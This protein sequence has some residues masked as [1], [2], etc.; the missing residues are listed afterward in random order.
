MPV[1]NVTKA[2]ST[3]LPDVDNSLSADS[4]A[5]EVTTPPPKMVKENA[6]ASTTTNAMLLFIKE[7]SFYFPA[8]QPIIG[9]VDAGGIAGKPLTLL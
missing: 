8:D 6:N 2:I 5:C 7:P 4:A 9:S 1:M 3:S